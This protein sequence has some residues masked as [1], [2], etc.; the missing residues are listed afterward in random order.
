MVV[1]VAGGI[2]LATRTGDVLDDAARTYF[3]DLL[4]AAAQGA[5]SS[6]R[7][8]LQQLL[9]GELG[10]GDRIAPGVTLYDLV[11]EVAEQVDLQVERDD[12][13]DLV[14]HLVT[15][16]TYIE[17][18]STTPT[19]LG[20][21]ADPRFSFA[22]GLDLDFRI[23]LP[24]TTQP[25]T[26]TGFTSVRV[27]SPVIDSHNLI[28][29]LAFLVNDLLRFFAGVDLVRLLQQFIADTD[30]APYVNDALAPLNAELTR[31]AAAGYWFLDAVV[32]VLDGSGSGLHGLSLPGAPAGRLDLLLTATG[33]DRSGAVEGVV[34]WPAALGDPTSAPPLDLAQAV[35]ALPASRLSAGTAAALQ[36]DRTSSW[37]VSAVEDAPAAPAVLEA[38]PATS[39]A[40]EALGSALAALDPSE[41]AAAAQDLRSAS[42]E[43]FVTLVGGLE[44][45]AALQEEFRR[46]RSDLVVT[47][48]T[49]VGGTGLFADQ[50]QVGRTAQLWA[51]DDAGT[52]RR[53][54]LVVEVPLDVPLQVTCALAP[55]HRWRGGPSEVVCRPHGWT[56]SVTVHPP[57]QLGGVLSEVLEQQVEVRLADRSRVF[58]TTAELEQRGIIIVSGRTYGDEV[59]LNP[60]PLPPRLADGI[61]VPRQ[62]TAATTESLVAAATASRGAS[63]GLRVRDALAT[64]ALV[65]GA[66]LQDRRWGT[67]VVQ[68]GEPFSEAAAAALMRN[69]PSGHGTAR[70]IDFAVS[71][72]VAPVVR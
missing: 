71:E 47:V 59:A 44:R 14:L 57:L 66:A 7:L 63:L 28:G 30:F 5:W 2:G 1:P 9:L 48:T 43:R 60:Q 62:V 24:P 70:G 68:I 64:G 25:L 56:G 37:T 65:K 10:L 17:A 42:A 51:D 31:L 69:D 40:D 36:A 61:A 34:S 72:Y 15:G 38:R 32:D 53:R 46:G 4:R 8:R 41:R 55:G 39:A 21:Y 52:H 33:F 6:Y 19:V 3:P 26:A 12:A 22:F 67:D 18:T 23:D 11:V 35:E 49:A 27:L 58:G 50:R 16:G 20:S 29:D 45:F 13:G 54:Y